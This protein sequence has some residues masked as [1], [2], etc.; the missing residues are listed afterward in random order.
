M[1]GGSPTDFDHVIGRGFKT[2]V[3]VERCDGPD[4][5]DGGIRK[6]SHEIKRFFGY[7]TQFVFDREQR[8]QYSNGRLRLAVDCVVDP[9]F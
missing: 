1:A 5:I 2:E 8:R 7:V 9:L 4:I 6:T 3:W